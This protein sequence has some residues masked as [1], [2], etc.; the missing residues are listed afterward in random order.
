MDT[1]I[2]QSL[3]PQLANVEAEEDL[4]GSVLIGG[5]EVWSEVAYV[6]PE[7]FYIHK[8]GWIWEAF[9]GLHARGMP[10]DFLTVQEE[11]EL[12]HRLVEAGGPAYLT[13]LIIGVPTSLHAEAYARIVMGE[14]AK[15]RAI[16]L[17]NRTAKDIYQANGNLADVLAGAA[18]G[19]D[20]VLPGRGASVPIGEA[21]QEWL[22]G[23]AGWIA[24]GKIPGITTGYPIL[25]RYT[26]GLKRGEVALLAGR[27]SMGKS[28]LAFQMADRQ[29]STGIRVGIFSL[30]MKRQDVPGRMKLA[31]LNLDLFAL[32]DSDLP[33]L[34]RQKARL[35]ELPIRIC[36]TSGLAVAEI[37]RE[38]RE[39]QRAL[40][41][42]DVMIVDHIGYIA[43]A[44]NRDEN[45]VMKIGNTMKGLARLAR[46]MDCAVLALSQLSRAV[47][48]RDDKAPDLPDL[49][50]SG[51]LEQDAR[52]VWMLH[53]PGYYAA[54][55]QQPPKDKP[56]KSFVIIRKNHNG[57]RGDAVPFAFVEK[58][59]R[60]A[61]WTG[62]VH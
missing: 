48:G 46:E 36:E 24:T 53:R 8:N 52:Q 13:T 5:L 17:M 27:P 49:R 25:D 54:L 7:D 61:E 34:A 35:Q 59:A 60:F 6:R 42:L 47:T 33:A 1:Q 19:L 40:G 23:V 2:I 31:A 45:T 4:L 9:A 56:Q 50:D 38:A 29:A 44:G 20:R 51:H 14:S 39:M 41:G 22:A 32:K 21:A 12:H 18:A 57:P 58:S 28:A 37:T 3:A 43:H 15:R 55:D 16:T 26:H 62:E 11:L 30:E 10:I